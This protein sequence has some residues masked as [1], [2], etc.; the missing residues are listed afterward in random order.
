MKCE[1]CYI[2]QEVDD[3]AKRLMKEA[4]MAET[5]S[6]NTAEQLY[7]ELQQLQGDMQDNKYHDVKLQVSAFCYYYIKIHM[8]GI[9]HLVDNIMVCFHVN[10][11][12][13]FQDGQSIR[14]HCHPL[15]TFLTSDNPT[16]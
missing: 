10:S 11:L 13:Y 14:T 5:F 3:K 2:K 15:N 16:Q 7:G 4:L 12:E 1:L 9:Y 8:K 6:L